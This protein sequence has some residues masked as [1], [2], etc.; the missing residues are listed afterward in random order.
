MNALDE[1]QKRII[2]TKIRKMF[3]EKLKLEIGQQPID[4]KQI[5]D[6]LDQAI[7]FFKEKY[8]QV[9]FKTGDVV[10]GQ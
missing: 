1:M 8:P 7:T 3:G 2:L 9:E 5:N 10:D 6:V 4:E